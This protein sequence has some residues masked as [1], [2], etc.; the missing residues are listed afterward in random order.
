MKDFF[1]IPM[2]IVFLLKIVGNFYAHS[3]KYIQ[4]RYKFNL[5][6]IVWV[7]F[8]LDCVNEFEEEQCPHQVSKINDLTC[9]SGCVCKKGTVRDQTTGK[10]VEP[11]QCGCTG[12]TQEWLECGNRCREPTCG[13]DKVGEKCPDD[14]ERTC[15][16]KTGYFRNDDDECV[17]LESCPIKI[18]HTCPLNEIRLCVDSECDNNFGNFFLDD[19][20]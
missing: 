16:C 14:C 4:V 9:Q 18:M 17:L 6:L 20:F 8:S 19:K 1:G 11:I 10:C 12:P 2:E 7:N 15:Q 3:M 13:K 5:F